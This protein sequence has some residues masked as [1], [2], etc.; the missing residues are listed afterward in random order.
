MPLILKLLRSVEEAKSADSDGGKKITADEKWA[1]AQEA[2]LSI[3]PAL[4]EGITD[5]LE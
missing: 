2:S 3:L 1:I 4:V 5:A